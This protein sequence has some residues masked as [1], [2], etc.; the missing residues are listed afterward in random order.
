MVMR[1][2]HTVPLISMS[3]NAA[4]MYNLFDTRLL[5]SLFVIISN[6]YNGRHVIK[7]LVEEK[8]FTKGFHSVYNVCT[9]KGFGKKIYV[10]HSANSGCCSKCFDFPLSFGFTADYGYRVTALQQFFCHWFIDMSQ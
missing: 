7:F 3:A 4:E 8:T 9:R 5:N 10:F 1:G 2:E 6:A